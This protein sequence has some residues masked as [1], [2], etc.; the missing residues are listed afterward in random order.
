MYDD[1]FIDKQNKLKKSIIRTEANTHICPQ[2][3]AYCQKNTGLDSIMNTSSD[4]SKPAI[5][6][7]VSSLA[8]GDSD[9]TLIHSRPSLASSSLPAATSRHFCF[10]ANT[11]AVAVYHDDL[12][13]RHSIQTLPAGSITI[14]QLFS[15]FAIQTLNATWQHTRYNQAKAGLATSLLRISRLNPPILLHSHTYTGESRENI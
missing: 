6:L 4:D 13:N 14:W 15:A 7:R 10:F 3:S 11:I 9:H 1:G 5:R 8:P 12:A 2:G